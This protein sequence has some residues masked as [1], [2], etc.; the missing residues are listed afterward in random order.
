MN[1]YNFDY[2]YKKIYLVRLISSLI[3]LYTSMILI[4]Y[5]QNESIINVILTTTG[6]IIFIMICGYIGTTLKWKSIWD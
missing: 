2:V 6:I 5:F 3:F 1:K 4:A